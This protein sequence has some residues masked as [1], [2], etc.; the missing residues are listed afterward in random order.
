VGSLLQKSLPVSTLVVAIDPGKVQN[1]VWL[2]TDESGL[3]VD[4]LSLSVLGPG[5]EQLDGLVH[6]HAGGRTAVFA[7]EA[8]GGLHRAW[9]AELNRRFPGAVRVFAPSETSAARMQLGSRRFKTDDRDCAALTYLARQGYGRAVPADDHDGLLAAVRHRRGLIQ[10]RKV[11]Q[12]RLHDQLNALCPGLSAPRGHGRKLDL[13]GVSGQAVLDC[14]IDL[15]GRPASPRSLQA[16]ATGRLTNTDARFWSAR[17]KDC[18]PGPADTPARIARLGRS[19]ARW[20]ALT[21]DIELV[22]ADLEL[23]LAATEGQVLTTLPGVKSVRAAAFAAFSMPIARF[24]DAER[25][26]SATGLAPASY[27]SST[28]DKRSGISRQGLPEHRDALMNMAWGLSQSCAPFSQRREEL[29]ARGMQPMQA[30]VALARHVCRLAHRMMTTQ[31]EFDEQRYR[32]NR[33]Q[34]GR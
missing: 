31:D 12:Q 30:R 5:L 14:L 18:L 10:E 1:R 6:R 13:V 2:S 19:V 11:A 33:H 29:H 24:P 8:T 23:L 34:T 9:V 3:I 4:P 22:D 17:W 21:V 28:I 15:G 7:I 20:R 25:L 26:Y 16:R 32:R 27:Q